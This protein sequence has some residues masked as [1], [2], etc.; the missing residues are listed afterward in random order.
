[1]YVILFIWC[2]TSICLSMW[3]CYSHLINQQYSPSNVNALNHLRLIYFRNKFFI[4]ILWLY[5]CWL[6]YI[7]DIRCLTNIFLQKLLIQRASQT[8]GSNTIFLI[9][10]GSCWSYNI[11]DLIVPRWA[12][13][14]TT[15]RCLAKVAGIWYI[16]CSTHKTLIEKTISLRDFQN[17]W[18]S[19]QWYNLF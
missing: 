1:M 13:W 5:H 2:S 9:V 18:M 4:H 14:K 11:R 6:T 16:T 12:H 3:N 15:K 8:I 17:N 7:N 10:R 19:N